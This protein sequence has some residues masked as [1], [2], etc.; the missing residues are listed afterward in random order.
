MKYAIFY[1]A[2]AMAIPLA[3]ACSTSKRFLRWAVMLMFL[4]IALY[5]ETAINFWSEETYRGTARGMEISLIYII[6]LIVV[7]A[8]TFKGKLRNPFA[9]WGL[10]IYLLY[11][12]WSALA[13]QNS[14]NL[15]YSW[16]ELWKM[17][18]MFLVFTA[19]FQWMKYSNGDSVTVMTG[20][21]IPV[22]WN[23]IEIIKQ[24]RYGLFQVRGVFMHQNSMAMF[25]AAIVPVFFAYYLTG[26]SNRH[27]RLFAIAFVCAAG[28]LIRTYSRGA[29]ACMPIGLGITALMCFIY[30]FRQRMVVR[31]LP[32]ALFGFLGVMA[33]LPRI[34][35]RFVNASEAS[36]NTRIEFALSARNMI[37]DQP[38]FGVGL[39]NWG[40]KINR[41]YPYNVR[42]WVL[43]P[44]NK[45][46][47]EYRDGIVETIYL[48]VAAECGMPCLVILLLWFA[49]YWFSAFRLCS[50]LRGTSQFYLPAGLFGGFTAI[51]MQS[52]LEWVLKQ[53][54]N[55]TELMA[56]FAM[57][58]YLNV[59]WRMIRK[60]E[61]TNPKKSEKK[62][63]AIEVKPSVA[64]TVSKE[65]ET[66]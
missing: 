8:I 54:V 49:W 2:L 47:E 31:L 26:R 41:P 12:A 23:F 33:I 53:H 59:H 29:M 62:P 55:F 19:V 7:I 13:F 34:I 18:M 48:L 24:H 14:H 6:A 11:F 44:T 40:L 58:G 60:R 30:N 39:N 57:T 5:N 65:P 10:V 45:W 1:M 15:M 32:I 16:F 52:T 17:M 9:D 22:L 63:A 66:K 37:E 51:F 25:M 27:W 50:K 3:I 56:L 43:N 4:P 36:G 64:E 20:L 61:L 35:D 42:E 46:Q 28:A 21:I 38:V